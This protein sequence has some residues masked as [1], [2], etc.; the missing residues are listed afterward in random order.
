MSNYP[1][2]PQP[3]QQHYNP[4]YASP[5][6]A[7]QLL[8]G[9]QQESVS[10]G[11]HLES[12]APYPKVE[13]EPLDPNTSSQI[14]QRIEQLNQQHQLEIQE[15]LHALPQH[16]HEHEHQLQLQHSHQQLA[17]SQPQLE[18][19]P[20]E[21][22]TPNKVNRLRK[23]CDSCSI[24]KVKVRCATSRSAFSINANTFISV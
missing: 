11:N 24:R 23:A 8:E 18:G 10:Y 4:I 7:Q 2:P 21:D 15:P 9:I 13:N 17:P 12:P 3:D 14:E 1:P 19:D 22:Q 16:Q 20:Q 6:G 5:N